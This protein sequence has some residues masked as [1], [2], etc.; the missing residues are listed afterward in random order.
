MNP[1]PLPAPRRRAREVKLGPLILGGD[2]PIRVQSMT[3]TDTADPDATVE[4]INAL[5][6]AG[7]EIVRLTVDTPKAAR[8]LPDIRRRTA[9]PL[10]ADI[11][12]NHRLAL[13]AAPYVDKIR[14]N[15]GNIGALENVKAVVARA[16]EFD[17]PIR[18]GVNQGSLEREIG[19]K[20]G[21]HLLDNVLLPPEEGYPAEAL[22]ES[23]LRNVEILEGFGFERIIISVKSSNVPLM[24]RAYRLLAEA[25]D[26]PLH[27]G[28][29]EAG[30]KDNSN[31]KSS[32]GIG[33][34]LLDGIGD[35][36]R[37]SIAARATEEKIEEVR[38]GYKILQAL[39]LRRF[40]VEVVSCPTCGREDQGFDTTRIAL[41]LE[42]LNSHLTRP[43]KLA[44]MGCY[45]NGPGE[46]ADADLGVV[47]SGKTAK[48][49]RSG[50][51][52]QTQVPFEEV[53]DRMSELIRQI[54]REQ[55]E[56]ITPVPT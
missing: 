40:G 7:C 5:A 34:L 49:Y 35:T 6:E 18:I 45:V 55:R 23:A 42:E 24:V 12:Y 46:A 26:Y 29:T 38:T 32:I 50:R 11:H 4:Q 13:E 37:V 2:Q 52:I 36:L 44:V 1:Q 15:P 30:T 3:A 16:N 17:L 39:G 31:I 27:L 51:L 47:A 19:L 56:E 14:I 53:V 41:Q 9:V 48:I 33:A 10:V 28:V 8:A 43:I 20:Y 54:D 21:A 25:C 22:V